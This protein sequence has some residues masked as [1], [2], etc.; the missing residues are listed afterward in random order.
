MITGFDLVQ[1]QIRIAGGAGLSVSQDQIK[2]AGHAI[3][4]RINAED[5]S[6]DF[7]PSPGRITRWQAPTG[8]ASALTAI[9]R[10]GDD[11]RS[12]TAWW[13]S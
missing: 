4:C 12:M 8:E 13:A 9:C 1:E 6:R 11:P 10:K 2:I 5:V 7:L 3:E